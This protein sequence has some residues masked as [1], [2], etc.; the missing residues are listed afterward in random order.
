[1]EWCCRCCVECAA[2]RLRC[3][4]PRS[5]A[6]SVAQVQGRTRERTTEKESQH[7]IRSSVFPYRAISKTTLDNL[8]EL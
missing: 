4:Y 3:Y 8:R 7:S 5:A 2:D 1:M 6:L